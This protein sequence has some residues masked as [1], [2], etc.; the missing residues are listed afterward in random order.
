[1]QLDNYISQL[2]Y[3]YQCVTVPGLGSF[4]T[5]NK[6]ARLSDDGLT[7]FPP[8]KSISFNSHLKHNDGLLANHIARILDIS[9]DSAL[10]SIEQEVLKW[11]SNLQNG[12]YLVL[13]NIG[14]LF[15][16]SE[17]NL[18]FES[19]GGLNYLKD[20]F[21][22]HALSAQ[23]ITREILTKQADAYR[24]K[25]F[26][27]LKTTESGSK[28]VWLKYAAVAV[29]GFGVLGFFGNNW[30]QNKISENQ[31][32]VEKS[33][34]EKIT[35]KIQEATFFIESPVPT[36]ILNLE[37]EKTGNYHVVAG[38][39]RE[40]ANAEKALDNL[41]SLGYKAQRIAP[42]KYGLHPVIYGSFSTAEEARLAQQQIKMEHNPDAWVLVQELN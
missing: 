10:K 38:A 41:L 2:L 19:S 31:L 12:E 17:Q 18:V 14:R 21:G 20:S 29:F 4:I 26:V 40:E 39:F 28:L 24:Q 36:V 7:F 15:L 27:V 34:Q 35:Q 5:E 42:N 32:I 16:N 30:Y 23:P 1:M 13:K 25:D 33:V 3:R 37:K 9:F 22:L 8:L 11:K 6:S